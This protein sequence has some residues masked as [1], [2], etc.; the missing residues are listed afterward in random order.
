MAKGISL[1]RWCVWCTRADGFVKNAA[2]VGLALGKKIFFAVGTV[3]VPTGNTEIYL[4]RSHSHQQGDPYT[5]MHASVDRFSNWIWQ[6]LWHGTFRS[7]WCSIQSRLFF[8]TIRN[9]GN[10]EMAHTYT[11]WAFLIVDAV[12]FLRNIWLF[13]LFKILILMY[14]MEMRFSVED[15]GQ[16]WYDF[17]ITT[18]GGSRVVRGRWSTTVV[19]IQYFGFG[20]REKTMERS[21][22]EIWSSGNELIFPCCD[23]MGRNRDTTR[24]N[25]NVSQRRGTI[26]E[27]K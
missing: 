24:R 22:T 17:F 3:L 18:N 11:P 5:R 19:Q 20:L 25:D 23:F 1:T 21:I 27:G 13:T 16:V 2:W 8:F 4:L 15:N 10:K 12:K 14:K 6:L 7:R 9:D 26:G